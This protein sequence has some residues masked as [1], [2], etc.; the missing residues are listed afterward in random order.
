MVPSAQGERLR[1]SLMLAGR[2]TNQHYTR[3]VATKAG[4]GFGLFMLGFWLMLPL[5]PFIT[6]MILS[7]TMALIGFMC[8]ASGLGGRSSR[9]S[10]R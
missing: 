7:I 5:A 1:R 8:R 9:A 2:P 6:T 10:T 3:F 4:L